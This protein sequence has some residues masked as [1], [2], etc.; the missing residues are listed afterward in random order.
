[1]AGKKYEI[2]D[3]KLKEVDM[4]MYSIN[5]LLDE[6]DFFRPDKSSRETLENKL[7]NTKS[8]LDN[9]LVTDEFDSLI[10]E[11][12]RKILDL[13]IEWVKFDSNKE[14]DVTDILKMSFGKDS[15]SEIEKG[16]TNFDIELY[17]QISAEAVCPELLTSL[18]EVGNAKGD[19][20]SKVKEKVLEYGKQAGITDEEFDF[21]LEFA[22]INR[23][24]WKSSENKCM[25]LTF[26]R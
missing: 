23:S 4:S 5:A 8:T 14:L 1:M 21:E 10:S 24:A 3:E 7:Y 18:K 15:I 13:Y 25:L 6:Y 26:P 20:S 17:K 11:N 16:I 9:I 2:K 19:I 12:I 22:P